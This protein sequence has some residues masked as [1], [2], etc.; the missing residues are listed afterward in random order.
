MRVDVT[1]LSKT[2]PGRLRASA[3]LL[4]V[5]A[6]LGAC[7]IPAVYLRTA[8]LPADTGAAECT[9]DALL[10]PSVNVIE[11]RTYTISSKTPRL[12]GGRSCAQHLTRLRFGADQSTW[13][14]ASQNAGMVAAGI[15]GCCL[16]P[17]R[18]ANPTCLPPDHSCRNWSLPSARTADLPPCPAISK[19]YARTNECAARIDLT[20]SKFKLNEY[21]QA[22]SMNFQTRSQCQQSVPFLHPYADVYPPWNR[23]S[24]RA[25]FLPF[26]TRHGV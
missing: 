16:I 7:A 1:R 18:S 4:V 19:K 11:Q 13:S 3:T 17:E 6:I 2:A 15:R 26:G 9:G 25:R 23:L 12:E 24:S 8:P 10:E 21:V 14:S 22:A 5:A 20:L